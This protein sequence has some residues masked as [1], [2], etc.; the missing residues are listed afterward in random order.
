MSHAAATATPARRI[1]RAVTSQRQGQAGL[2]EQVVMPPGIEVEPGADPEAEA[3]AA[4]AVVWFVRYALATLARRPASD[5]G[6][7]TELVEDAADVLRSPTIR[8]DWQSRHEAEDVGH[9]IEW[10]NG[11]PRTEPWYDGRPV[12]GGSGPGSG[13]EWWRRPP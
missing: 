12:T 3:A 5:P 8:P 10:Y 6:K 13:P 2:I 9:P 11:E 7:V 1:L 4:R